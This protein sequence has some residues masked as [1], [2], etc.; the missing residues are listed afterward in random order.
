M[1]NG[2]AKEGSQVHFRLSLLRN[3]L[4]VDV[5]PTQNGIIQHPGRSGGDGGLKDGRESGEGLEHE[6]QSG[7]RKEGEKKPCVYFAGEGCRMG[8][9][10]NYS[11]DWSLVDKKAD[12]CW[13][14]GSLQHRKGE[15]PVKHEAA[16]KAGFR[17][18]QGEQQ[19]QNKSQ[20]IKP[21][22]AAEKGE[23]LTEA[24]G[25]LKSLSIV[26]VIRV[27]SVKLE[28]EFYGLLDG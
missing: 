17:Q 6:A 20:P 15:C 2:I 3:S 21:K 18:A 28:E 11:H 13:I 16:G 25:L 4:E 12:L 22:V 10:C 14:C 7:Q 24:T 1:T 5:T 26:K 9:N 23:L 19:Q 8:R 27:R